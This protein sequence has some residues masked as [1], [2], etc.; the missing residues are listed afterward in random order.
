MSIIIKA[1]SNEAFPCKYDQKRE[2]RR[3]CSKKIKSKM[4][5]IIKAKSK[6]H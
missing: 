1:K 5:I 4:S 6:Q 3:K 2:T